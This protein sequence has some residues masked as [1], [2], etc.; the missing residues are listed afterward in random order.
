MVFGLTVLRPTGRHFGW[1]R[2]QGTNGVNTINFNTNYPPVFSEITINPVPYAAIQLGRPSPGG[3]K[4]TFTRQPKSNTLRLTYPDWGTRY[5]IRR[6]K[7]QKGDIVQVY[8]GGHEGLVA[9]NG[10]F[11]VDV[12]LDQAEGY[13]ELFLPAANAQP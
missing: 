13:F 6:R 12:A 5:A 2:L 11:T 8:A 10:V 1:A 9:N 7:K 3:P 4:L